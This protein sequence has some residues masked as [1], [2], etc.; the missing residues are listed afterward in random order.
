MPS[1]AHQSLLL[2]GARRMIADGFVLTGLDGRVEQAGVW[3][4]VPVPFQI[5]GVRPDA[6][7][8]RGPGGLIAF[9]EAKTHDDVDNAHTRAQLRVLGHA[10]MRDG[11]T[12]CPLYIAVPRSAA[13]AL[14]RVLVD[15]GLIGSS[16]VRRL[17]VPSVLLG[18]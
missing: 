7:G 12:R 4:P 11:K 10:R 5:H 18:D 17:H 13:Y 6:C 16:H 3:G 8:V 1:L 9:T 15:V 14:D 2:W